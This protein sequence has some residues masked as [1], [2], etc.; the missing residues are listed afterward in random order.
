MRRAV[1]GVGTA[2]HPT[3]LV[4]HRL[5]RRAL[6]ECG[7]ADADFS[8]AGRQRHRSPTCADRDAVHRHRAR[9]RA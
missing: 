4:M 6:A 3:G 8:R 9:A 5:G 7:H 1:G 2:P